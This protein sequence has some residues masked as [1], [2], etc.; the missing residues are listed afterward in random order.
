MNVLK[1]KKTTWLWIAAG[2]AVLAALVWAF[3]PRPVEVETAVIKQGHF[4]QSIEEDGRTRIKDR[5][6]VSA[7]VAAR[8]ARMVLREGDPVA[9]GDVVAVLTPVM[10]SMV[11]ERSVREATAR[12]KAA[13]AGVERASARV[14]RARISL[15]EAQLEKERTEKLAGEGFL[16]ASK[17][18]AVR[19]AQSGARRELEVAD[20]EREMAVQEKAQAAAALQPAAAGS[21]STRPLS[22]RSPVSGVVL[23]VPQPSEATLAAG[24][25]LLDIGDP[26][27]M[28]VISELLTTDA[29]Q[30]TAGRRVVI[31]RW[32][33]PPVEGVVRR[34]EPA[35]FT[36]V[37]ALGIEEQR[38]NVLIDVSNPPEA[39][40]SMGDGF[41]VSVRIITASVEQAVLAPLGA[42]FPHG[43]GMAVY[44]LDGREARLQPV[45]VGARNNNEAW[46]RS[47]LTE[48]QTVIVYPPAT[49]RDGS[50]VQ[51]RKP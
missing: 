51:V 5:Y 47:G 13:A 34:V 24:A 36:K 32:G 10:S 49:L 7:P 20:A 44:R 19:L 6:T 15:Q 30:A 40:R 39:W 45:E 50:R 43:K 31:E 21:S 37:S 14:A 38:V 35:A 48:G 41:R 11:D 29:V 8:V 42:L 3:S 18:D 12:L 1:L 26:Q 28:E 9:A 33:G 27:R 22:V 23:R 17:L 46:L 16:S 2:V 25:A 4:E